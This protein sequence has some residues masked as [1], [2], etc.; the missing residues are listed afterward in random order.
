MFDVRRSLVSFLIRPAVFLAGGWAENPHPQYP[1]F[2]KPEPLNPEPLN[3]YLESAPQAALRTLPPILDM[4]SKRMKVI[5]II[6]NAMAA[7]LP[8]SMPRLQFK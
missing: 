6:R 4:I 5:T 3:P 8:N 1:S 7:A 2:K